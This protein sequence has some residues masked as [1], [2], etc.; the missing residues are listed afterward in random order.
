MERLQSDKSMPKFFK[1]TLNMFLYSIAIFPKNYQLLGNIYYFVF[2]TITSIS[3]LGSIIPVILLSDGKQRLE[4]L[5]AIVPQLTDL[6]TFMYFHYKRKDVLKVIENLSRNH[7]NAGE[8]LVATEKFFRIKFLVCVIIHTIWASTFIVAA[9]LYMLSDRPISEKYSLMIPYWY[10]C[11]DANTKTI[12]NRMCWKIDTKTELWLANAFS[13]LSVNFEYVVYSTPP[14]FYS[15]LM[16]NVWKHLDSFKSAMTELIEKMNVNT[17][18]VQNFKIKTTARTIDRHNE[19][20]Y[21]DFREIVKYQ[22][23]VRR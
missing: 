11:G 2:V 10:S 9:I 15:I 7:S 19:L 16:A 1:S 6:W 21:R 8:V 18:L 14:I 13:M 20:I 12:F 17:R 23:F 4:A 5:S 3:V 22:Q